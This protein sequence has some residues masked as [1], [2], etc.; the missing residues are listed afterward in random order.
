MRNEAAF[1][2][3]TTLDVLNAQQA[4]LNARVN[5]VTAQRDRMV[6]SYA[7]LAATGLLSASTLD[8]DVVPYDPALHLDEIESKWFGLS[9]EDGR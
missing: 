8:L 4:L 1:G 9:V 2:Q 3:R 5:L 6:G 7:L